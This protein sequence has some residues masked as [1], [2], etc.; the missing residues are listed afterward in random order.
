MT[1]FVQHFTFEFKTG[2]RNSTLLFMNYLFPLGVYAV[3]GLVMTQVNPFFSD[4]LLPAMIIFVILGST[5]LGLPSPLVEAREAGVYRNFKINGVPA[6]SIVAIPVLTTTFHALIAAGIVALTAVP[7]FDGVAPNR[8][9]PVAGIAVLTAFTC[10]ALGALIG[11]VAANNRATTLLSQLIFLP[12]MLIGGLMVPLNMLP[13]AVQRFAGLLPTAHAMQAFEGLAYGRATTFAPTV[14][15]LILLTSSLL[16]FGMAIYLFNW[17]SRNQTRRGHP[18]MALVVLV[19][20][21][22]G[23]VL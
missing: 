4:S 16:A 9:W 20:Y 1:A 23:M 12:S 3:M 21:L 5:I 15:L 14:S 11:V 6:A 18:L 10:S 7:V 8:W 2:L 17:D 19:P 13:E 22:V